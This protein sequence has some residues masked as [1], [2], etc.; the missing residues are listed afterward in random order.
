MSSTDGNRGAIN[1]E[2]FR[3]EFFRRAIVCHIAEYCRYYN[4]RLAAIY[5]R[6]SVHRNEGVV[7]T[8]DLDILVFLRDDFTEQD[9]AYWDMNKNRLEAEFPGTQGMGYACP[10]ERALALPSLLAQ[11]KHDATLVFGNDLIGDQKFAQPD[12][13]PRLWLLIRFL[14]GVDQR[15]RSESVVPGEPHLR[16]RR[17]ARMAVWGG[18]GHL[19]TLNKLKSY[20]GSDVLPGVLAVC[21]QWREFIEYTGQHYAVVV[22]TSEGEVSSYEA[23][24]IRWVLWVGAQRVH[25]RGADLPIAFDE[26][27]DDAKVV[28]QTIAE[29][30]EGMISWEPQA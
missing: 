18:A 3:E 24:L 10:V 14:A 30:P 13:F 16:L 27:P 19:F 11:L 21:P 6:G 20:S 28:R 1:L 7:G 25:L 22:P 17:L 12:Y 29:I 4:D 26:M 8:S 5:I 2:Y 9:R 23:K 15:N